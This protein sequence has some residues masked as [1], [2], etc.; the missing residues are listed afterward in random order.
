[1]SLS[2]PSGAGGE[3]EARTQRGSTPQGTTDI[4]ITRGSTTHE[5]EEGREC[6]G[7]GLVS[8]GI[9]SIVMQL[10]AVSSSI[11]TLRGRGRG[12]SAEQRNINANST[13]YQP[14]RESA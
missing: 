8:I 5:G 3:G 11:P 12:T 10:L 13:K 2:Q 6:K 14:T 1:M 9:D 7:M 4:I